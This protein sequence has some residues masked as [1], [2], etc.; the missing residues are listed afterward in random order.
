MGRVVMLAFVALAIASSPAAAQDRAAR[1][2]A[3]A[4]A[5]RRAPAARPPVGIRAYGLFDS[6][7]MSASQSFDAVLGTSRLSGFGVGGD[8]LHVWRGVFARVSFSSF[9]KTG[10]RAAVSGSTGTSLN[11]PDKVSMTPIELGGGWRFAPLDKRGRIATYL[12]LGT[13]L[14]KYSETSDHADAGENTSATYHGY[15]FF[16]GMDV[17]LA[18][19]L[20]L[21]VEGEIRSVPNA[22][23]QHGTSAAFGETNLGGA[24]LRFLFGVSR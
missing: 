8:V 19:H 14:L 23:G 6:E 15:V 4:P 22:I 17:T 11:I 13:L 7:H 9:S 21:G 5:P 20:T 2:Q 3:A 24:A 10:S 18:R 12:G 16:G 1:E